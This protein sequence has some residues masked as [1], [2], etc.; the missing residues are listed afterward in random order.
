MQSR[1]TEENRKDAKRLMEDKGLMEL[2]TKVMLETEDEITPETVNSKTNE[3]LGEI[4]RAR[5]LAE[6]KVLQRFGILKTISVGGGKPNPTP[7]K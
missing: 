1:F 5:T 2:L 3:Q 6:A 7:R 4:V